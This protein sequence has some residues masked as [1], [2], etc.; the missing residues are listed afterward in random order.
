MAYWRDELDREYASANF[1][2]G[3]PITEGCS[4]LAT[5]AAGGELPSPASWPLATTA[6]ACET[7]RPDFLPRVSRSYRDE[8][9]RTSLAYGPTDDAK[10]F[11]YDDA[12]RPI[13]TENGRSLPQTPTSGWPTNKGPYG[14]IA[15]QD[16]NTDELYT[17][18]DHRGRIREITP[19]DTGDGGVEYQYPSDFPAGYPTHTEPPASSDNDDPVVMIIPRGGTSLP[20]PENRRTIDYRYNRVGY[21]T[22]IYEP[23]KEVDSDGVPLIGTNG[24]PLP[25]WMMWKTTFDSS[26]RRESIGAAF[27][28]T[29]STLNSGPIKFRTY[30]E[31][32]HLGRLKKVTKVEAP[33]SGPEKILSEIEWDFDG[34]R[35]L[36]SRDQSLIPD[37]TLFPD[38]DG[39]VIGMAI[40]P[41]TRP[42]LRHRGAWS[43]RLTSIH[44]PGGLTVAPQYGPVIPGSSTTT[45]PTDYVGDQIGRVSQLLASTGSTAEAPAPSDPMNPG[46]LPVVL[47]QGYYGIYHPAWYEMPTTVGETTQLLRRP[48][49]TPMAIIP[50]TTYD[51]PTFDPGALLPGTVYNAQSNGL[52]PF[53]QYEN[54]QWSS[55]TYSCSDVPS[56]TDSLSYSKAYDMVRAYDIAGRPWLE[57]E[58]SAKYAPETR[59]FAYGDTNYTNK[60]SNAESWPDD[61]ETDACGTPIQTDRGPAIYEVSSASTGHALFSC[62]M[63]VE[64]LDTERW[65]L[66]TQNNIVD[67]Y[68]ST[69]NVEAAPEQKFAIG[70]SDATYDEANALTDYSPVIDTV[71]QPQRVLAYDDAGNMVDN[72]KPVGD[73]HA[74]F[75]SYDH[76]NRLIAAYR[77][78]LDGEDTVVGTMFAKFSYDALG[79]MASSVYDLVSPT[80]IHR[81]GVAS[82]VFDDDVIEYYAHDDA[83]RVVCV[84]RQNAVGAAG[85]A[86]STVRPPA[87]AYERFV[88]AL[89]GMEGRGD[90]IQSLSPIL[91]QI[92]TNWDD[93]E[94]DLDNT[95]GEPEFE[96][97]RR[98]LHNVMGDVVGVVEDAPLTNPNV[99]IRYSAFG[100]PSVVPFFSTADFDDGSGLGVPDGGL[101]IDDLIYYNGLYNYGNVRADLDGGDYTLVPDGGVTISDLLAYL[102]LNA[103]GKVSTLDDVRFA[104]RGYQYDPHLNLYHV[105]H[106]V[107]DPELGRWLQRDPAGFVDGLNLYAYTRSSPFGKWD[108]YGLNEWSTLDYFTTGGLLLMSLDAL[109]GGGVDEFL[110]IRDGTKQKE[111]SEYANMMSRTYAR[112]VGARVKEGK[113]KSQAACLCDYLNPYTKDGIAMQ[114]SAILEHEAKEIGQT[115]VQSVMVAGGLL[116]APAAGASLT[117]YIIWGTVTGAA[118]D[119]G[120]QGLMM[121]LGLQDEY[122]GWQTVKAGL[123]GGAGGAATNGLLKVFGR[124][125]L[126]GGR[127]QAPGINRGG[128]SPLLDK[129]L[130]GSGGRWGSN[131]TRALN[132]K[133]ALELEEQGFSVYGGA[134][135]ASEEWIPGVGGAKKGGTFVDISATNGN[136]TIRIQTIDTLA[137]G[138]TPTAREAA[139]AERIRRAFPNDQLRLIPKQ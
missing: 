51:R 37:G 129:Y 39:P 96:R 78:V 121:V 123:F 9:G 133:I 68:R 55:C 31:Y 81:T 69:K 98:F 134:G 64:P 125:P 45:D 95:A 49:V 50:S 18:Y 15:F 74:F 53:G 8:F 72:G 33:T 109:S 119:A 70:I 47:R 42:F 105:R 67:Y 19:T 85:S 86:S 89:T 65:Q 40:T 115:M 114:M 63:A 112:C 139:A 44:Y 28:D 135:R 79:R 104:Y 90:P 80:T 93:P 116:I 113:S 59:S 29:F 73:P 97:T 58:R 83:W 48:L 75:Y 62:G 102:E 120:G 107:L 26:G 43:N 38:G 132:N 131:S 54:D 87:V 124:I 4:E 57:V 130:S 2:D 23:S 16:C 108:P 21:P 11:W 60:L 101:T 66:D 6:E 61:T 17:T 30:W 82:S 1:G 122:D 14:G 94:S 56:A 34:W 138:I 110:D 71:A 136:T 32:D 126:P 127:G 10:R 12:G 100:L 106:R 5:V 35:N 111:E 22:H 27:D 46:S 13:H 24:Q 99:R 36:S 118:S 137:D 77:K 91:S 41:Y 76:E 117:T 92:N 7:M 20:L 84:F 3:R 88:Y 25:G 128:K 52:N 103:N